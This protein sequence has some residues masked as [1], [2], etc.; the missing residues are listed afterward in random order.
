[1]LEV[2]VDTVLATSEGLVLGAQVVGPKNAWIRFTQVQV[3]WGLVSYELL[4]AIEDNMSR[5]W[6]EEAEQDGLF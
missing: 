1:M 3:P 6:R 2:K 5:T 4:Q